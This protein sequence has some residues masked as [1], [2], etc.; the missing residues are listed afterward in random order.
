MDAA[1]SPNG[2][3]DAM[4]VHLA[5]ST[6]LRCAELTGLRLDQLTLEPGAERVRIIG[7]GHKEREVPLVPSVAERL[8]VYLRDIRPALLAPQAVT[9]PYVFPAELR[10]WGTRAR[11]GATARRRVRRDRP[12]GRPLA[13]RSFYRIAAELSRVIGRPIHPHLFRHSFAS[14]LR[15]AGADLQLIQELLGHESIHTTTMYAHITTDLQRATLAK[16]L[17]EG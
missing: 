2:R 12:R 13:T 7:K 5:L 11:G 6:G 1:T 16:L 8:R 10:P 15:A 14:R 3:R 17:G 4:M 9:S